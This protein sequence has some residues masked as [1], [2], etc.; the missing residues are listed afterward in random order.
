MFNIPKSNSLIIG[1]LLLL[2]SF[3]GLA[4]VPETIENMPAG[5]IYLQMTHMTSNDAY[6]IKI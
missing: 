6:D 3:I 5:P 2:Y 4:W 1:P